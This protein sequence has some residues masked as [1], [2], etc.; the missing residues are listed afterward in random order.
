MID[1]HYANFAWEQTEALLAVDSPSGYTH[2]AAAWVKNAFEKL[3]FSAT[4][5]TKG[6]FIL[7]RLCH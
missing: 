4:L 7:K 5:T 2:K 3:G 1:L 6:P